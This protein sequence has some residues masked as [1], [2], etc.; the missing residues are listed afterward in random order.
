MELEWRGE[1]WNKKDIL[2]IRPV[3]SPVPRINTVIT[4]V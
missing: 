4:V 1:G 3:V 2:Y